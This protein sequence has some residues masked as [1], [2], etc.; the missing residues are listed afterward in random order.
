MKKV[1]AWLP[2]A[3]V[4]LFAANAT[5]QLTLTTTLTSN[6]GGNVG[7]AVHFD[8]T[9]LN[10]SGV[11][12]S[13]IDANCAN[14]RGTPAAIDIYMTAVNGTYVG[15]QVNPAP[16]VWSLRATAPLVTAGSDVGAPA[17]LNNPIP[18][19]PGRYGVT[20]VHRGCAARYTGTATVPPTQTTFSNGDIQIDTGTAQNTPFVSG[21]FSP[22][23]ANVVV[24][25]A[26]LAAD[27]CAFSADV[28][29]GTSPL[30]VNFT[31]RSVTPSGPVTA[32][33]WDFDGDNVSDSNQQNPLFV[34]PACGD[35]PV[36][37]TVTAPGGPV[38]TT[39]NAHVQVDPLVAGFTATPDLG[40]APLSVLFT[41]TSSSTA[42]L[43]S[44]DFDG[45][46]VPDSSLQNPSH[47]FGPGA[48]EVSLTVV[49]G[50]R[51]EVVK[52]RITVASDTF[53][54][55]GAPNSFVNLYSVAFFDL[56]VTATEALSV[57]A[58]DF[59]SYTPEGN[60][61]VVDVYLTDTTYTGKITTPAVWRKVATATGVTPGTALPAQLVLDRPI[62][63][64]PGRSYGVGLHH[65][66]N[67]SYYVNLT[68]PVSNS[69]LTLTPGAVAYSP[70]GPFTNAAPFSIRQW[71]GRIHYNR[72]TQAP[73]GVT[74]WFGRGCPGSLG[75]PTLAP[76]GNERPTL[77]S[78]TNFA[79]GGL[80]QSVVFQLIGFSDQLGP[81][82]PLPQ[83]LSLFGAP[84]CE[85]HV[86]P[87]FS[88]VLFGANNSANWAFTAP[89]DP[90][91]A[92][93]LFFAQGLALSPGSNVLGG[94]T[95]D[96][97]GVMLGAY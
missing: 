11:L 35:F 59:R 50:C 86:S 57:C 73:Q 49:N 71:V 90:A 36:R 43:W 33:D 39:W 27:V 47:T 64:L 68:A 20:I 53:D 38:T 14:P 69:D 17:I 21:A 12:L 10:P 45:D 1:L 82:G 93:L 91:L 9:V 65:I 19:A 80:P 18:L 70:N 62:L 78:V 6:N 32:W 13:Q 67:A 30:I 87:D 92:G 25:Y 28:T 77:G 42:S 7:G 15:N 94:V 85:L 83:D 54:T 48:H 95:T 72:R 55:G 22:R 41:D 8:L 74:T 2:V 76:V 60:P 79:F 40:P 89:L 16:G 56:A 31:D 37:L 26:V 46:S 84:G 97:V 63:L 58:I 29:S 3:L 34:F 23:V 52:K 88:N 51:A 96:A 24:H 66:D 44:W 5:A 75:V 81:L 4:S 61:M